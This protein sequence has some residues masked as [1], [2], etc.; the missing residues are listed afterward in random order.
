MDQHIADKLSEQF[1]AA[2]MGPEYARCRGWF[3][4]RA[5]LDAAEKLGDDWDG[6]G[7]PAVHKDAVAWAR[8]AA[9]CMAACGFTA[10]D[11]VVAGVGGTIHFEWRDAAGH[12]FEVEASEEGVAA[13]CCL[14]RI[15]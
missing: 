10:P 14:P 9:Q 5:S 2:W 3:E 15:T 11:R 13:F 7:A 12:Y 8:K 4:A 1:R 6:Q